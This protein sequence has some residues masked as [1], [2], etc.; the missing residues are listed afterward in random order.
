MT[1]E[2][3]Y[4]QLVERVR[5]TYPVHVPGM[6]PADD[7]QLYWCDACREINLWTY[8]QGRGCLHP[9]IL[10]V[11][12]DWGCPWDSG[13]ARTMGKIAAMNRGQQVSYIQDSTNPTDT[14]LLELFKSIGYDLTVPQ[15][16]LFFTNFVLGYRRHGTAGG[17]QQAWADHDTGF[18]RE[19]A[20]LLQPRVILCLGQSTT[21]AVLQALGRSF[22]CPQGY[23]AFLE[24]PDNPISVTL[25]GGT[26]ARVFAL[27]HCGAMGTLNRNAKAS[28]DLDRQKADWARIVPFLR[29]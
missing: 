19:L 8:W 23:N 25:A 3:Q 20:D 11:G 9:K 29:P 1:K 10:L 13:A 18:F 4:A 2:T 21:R 24:G 12:Q 7:G 17:F 5:S 22:R 15:P 26:Q 16:D 28:A 6:I 14:H 27:A